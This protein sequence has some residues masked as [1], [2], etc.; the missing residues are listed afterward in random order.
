MVLES[1]EQRLRNVLRALKRKGLTVSNLVD[2][3]SSAM[4]SHEKG[5]TANDMLDIVQQEIE[6]ITKCY[7]KQACD[8]RKCR[9][10]STIK[11]LHCY[12]RTYVVEMCVGNASCENVLSKCGACKRAGASDIDHF[13]EK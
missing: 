12:N 13:K 9:R 7:I 1:N 2:V 3:I 10:Y 6:G 5:L 8:G 4:Q 11:C